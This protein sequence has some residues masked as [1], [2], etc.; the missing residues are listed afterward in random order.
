M[1]KDFFQAALEQY[2]AYHYALGQ[3][4]P[5]RVLYLAIPYDTYQSFFQHKRP[6]TG[7]ATGQT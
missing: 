5:E 6:F 1:A 2:L 7:F 3:F 4:E